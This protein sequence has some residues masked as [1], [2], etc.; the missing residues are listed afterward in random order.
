[1]RLYV[2]GHTPNS[3]MAIRNLETVCREHLEGRFELEVIDINEHPE[4]VKREELFAIPTLIK[5]LPKPL[6]KLI[7]DL[8]D[9][10]HVL[11][12]LGLKPRREPE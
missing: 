1:M 10:E 4:A 11:I 3:R 12:G 7:G 6:R 9:T 8:S 5:D 2:N